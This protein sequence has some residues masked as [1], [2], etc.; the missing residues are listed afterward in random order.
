MVS[1][2]SVFG[3]MDRTQAIPTDPWKLSLDS[4]LSAWRLKSRTLASDIERLVKERAELDERIRAAEVLL[5]RPHMPE[6]HAEDAPKLSVRGAMHALMK[7]GKVR[8]GQEIR[9]DL[10]AAGYDPHKLRTTAG[11]FYS[12]L[13]RLVETKVLEKTMSGAYKIAASAFD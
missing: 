12:S 9:R 1:R 4:E 2:R 6:M 5:G 10:I 8:T 13:T 11:A 3:G 7:D